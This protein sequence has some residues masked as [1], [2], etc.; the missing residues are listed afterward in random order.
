[1]TPR[2]IKIT[3]KVLSL[4]EWLET[5]MINDSFKLPNSFRVKLSDKLVEIKLESFAAEQLE[6]FDKC[7]EGD[8]MCNCGSSKECGY[9]NIDN[10]NTRI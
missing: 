9:S 8:N 1:M 4:I 7:G 6:E 5:E 3:E 2:Q 10:L